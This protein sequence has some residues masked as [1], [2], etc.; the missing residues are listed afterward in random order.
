MNDVPSSYVEYP[1]NT[2][3]FVELHPMLSIRLSDNDQDS[4]DVEWYISDNGTDWTHIQTNGSVS[5]C[6][7]LTCEYPQADTLHETYWWK[8]EINDS[9]VVTTDIL[10]FYTH[11]L[12]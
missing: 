1:E 12:F 3:G 10:Y 5:T 11:S 8:V 2:D 4:L 9:I 6:E 7:V